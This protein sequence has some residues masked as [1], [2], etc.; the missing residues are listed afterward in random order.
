MSETLEFYEERAR[1][2]RAAAER[3]ALANVRD[4]ELRSAA[5]WEGLADQARRAERKR[6]LR[7]EATG[8]KA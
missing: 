1:E 3:A 5:V 7:E 2:A 6:A 4:R 8:Q